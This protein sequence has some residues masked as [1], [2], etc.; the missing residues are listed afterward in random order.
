MDVHK[1][2]VAPDEQP[3][4]H[5]QL[6]DAHTQLAVLGERLKEAGKQQG[7]QD[8]CHQHNV[9]VRILAVK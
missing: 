9:R 3:E 1:L 2:Q 5:K 4:E 6:G 8:A 7:E